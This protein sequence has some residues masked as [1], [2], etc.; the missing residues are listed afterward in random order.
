MIFPAQYVEGKCYFMDFEFKVTPDTFIPRPETEILVDTI[1]HDVKNKKV[2]LKNRRILDI[3]TGSGNIAISLTKYIEHCTIYGLD[4][5]YN[6]II[7]A[8]F[9]AMMNGAGDRVFFFQSDLFSGVNSG[10]KFDIIVSN[11]PYISKNDMDGLPDIVRHEPVTALSGGIDGLDYYRKIINQAPCYL[12]KGGF[13]YF[14]IGYDQ[15]QTVPEILDEKG[16]SSIRV[17]K[18]YSGIDR[19]VKAKW[20]H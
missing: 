16:Y 17:I 1:V 15:G 6:C 19:I 18:D 11:P 12:E 8:M 2:D 20:T 9:N 10:T 7:I 3:G 4:I 13:I 5:S 14:E